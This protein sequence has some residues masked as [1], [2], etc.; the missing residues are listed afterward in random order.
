MSHAVHVSDETYEEIEKLARQRGV[1]AESLAD[2]LLRERLA[3]RRALEQ[4]NEEWGA[5]LD[6][7]LARAARGENPRYE[8]T[9]EFFAALDGIGSEKRG[10]SG[11]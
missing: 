4:Q 5:G 2:V 6:D 8:S 1:T 10:K 7:A 11:A 3:E 9:E